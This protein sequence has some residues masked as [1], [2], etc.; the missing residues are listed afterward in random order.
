MRFESVDVHQIKAI[1]LP[2]EIG[3]N[4]LMATKKTRRISAIMITDIVGYTAL[5]QKENTVP[6][7]IGL[8]LGILFLMVP[9]SMGTVLI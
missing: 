2:S 4:I 5:M 1:D 8:H 7:R 9:K 6:L 3:L